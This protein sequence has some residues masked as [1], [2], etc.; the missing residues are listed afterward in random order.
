[1]WLWSSLDIA[2]AA[3]PARD[4]VLAGVALLEFQYLNAEAVWVNV[5]PG[6]RLDPAVPLAVR[7]HIVLTSKEDLVRV[8][9]L[10]L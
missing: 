2:P 6:S 4:V 7:L 3:V 1:M 5:W 8:F 10:K 9:A